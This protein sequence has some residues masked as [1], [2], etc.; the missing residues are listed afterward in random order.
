MLRLCTGESTM[1][2][3]KYGKE[4]TRGQGRVFLAAL[5]IGLLYVIFF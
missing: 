3:R 2:K 5:A 1:K 4:A